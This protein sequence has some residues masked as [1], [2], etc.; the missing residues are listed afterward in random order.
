MIPF[1]ATCWCSR[2]EDGYVNCIH[3]W[4]VL[5]FSGLIA[6]YPRCFVSETGSSSIS[7]MT[8][9]LECTT[10]SFPKANLWKSDSIK[11]INTAHV[12]IRWNEVTHVWPR[13]K[14]PLQVG[15]SSIIISGLPPAYPCWNTLER[16]QKR[17]L[18][19][20]ETENR[21]RQFLVSSGQGLS[22]IGRSTAEAP[23]RVYL[24]LAAQLTSWGSSSSIDQMNQTCT[25]P[26]NINWYK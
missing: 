7:A 26:P 3:P 1:R 4:P 13:L 22:S 23:C 18:K 16:R 9:S 11:Y 2:P 20:M 14:Q 12:E 21:I 15:S 10:Q 6:R 19:S 17:Y 24:R 25:Y 5:K 8:A